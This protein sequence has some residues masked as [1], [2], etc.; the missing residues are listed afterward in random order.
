MTTTI[1]TE[2]MERFFDVAKKTYE[3]SYEATE[4]AGKLMTAIPSDGSNNTYAWLPHTTSLTVEHTADYAVENRKFELT[5]TLDPWDIGHDKLGLYPDRFTFLGEQAK[6]HPLYLFS[7]ALR[8]PG[9][10][11]DGLP[12]FHTEH[13][14]NLRDI[15]KGVYSNVL[16]ASLSRVNFALAVARIDIAL[17]RVF[18]SEEDTNMVVPTL[19]VPTLVVPP[20]RADLAVMIA[21]NVIVLPELAMRPHDWYVLDLAHAITPIFHQARQQPTFGTSQITPERIYLWNLMAQIDPSTITDE[22]ARID[23]TEFSPRVGVS[24]RDAVGYGH[25]FLAVKG[26]GA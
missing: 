12:F 3:A 13:P 11:Y 23:R 16:T 9:I 7:L 18:G 6:K 22:Q 14:I 25:P 24:V 20:Q 5:Y 10:G 15:S 17:H 2:T 8:E 1:T 4:G 26:I 21:S 19:V